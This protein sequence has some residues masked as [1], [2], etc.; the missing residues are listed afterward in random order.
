MKRWNDFPTAHVSITGPHRFVVVTTIAVPC[1][2][3]LVN[4]Y[5]HSCSKRINPACFVFCLF[6]FCFCMFF[7]FIFILFCFVFCSELD[8]GPVSMVNLK[9]KGQLCDCFFVCLW[10]IDQKRSLYE[11]G[12]SC[13][14]L[15]VVGMVIY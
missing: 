4:F 12:C 1:Q 3:L 7:V 2:A 11:M 6:V 15:V 13:F 9:N 8:Q 5:L 10:L 14:C